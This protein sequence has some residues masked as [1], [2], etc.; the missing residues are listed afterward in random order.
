MVHIRSET[1]LDI[2]GIR[3][4]NIQA[5]GKEKEANL[6]AA[7]RN[8]SNFIPALSLIAT[9]SEQGLVGHILFSKITI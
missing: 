6:V 9:D 1:P 5:F 7:I 8:S 4:I 2:E 3:N